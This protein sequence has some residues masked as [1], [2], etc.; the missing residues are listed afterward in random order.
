MYFCT[1]SCS[2]N[3]YTGEMKNSGG[4]QLS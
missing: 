4:I 2:S 1:L 3:L